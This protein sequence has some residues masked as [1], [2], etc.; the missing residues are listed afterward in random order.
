MK[1]L[2]ILTLALGLA[3][4]V[5]YTATAQDFGV[6]TGGEGAGISMDGG[7]KKAKKKKKSKKADKKADKKKATVSPVGKAVGKLKTFNG[8]PN[9]KAQVYI[10]LQSASWCGPCNQEMPEVAEAYKEMEKDG[11]AELILLGHDQTEDGAKKFLKQYKA[12]FPGILV[13]GKGVDKLPGFQMAQGI[14]HAIMVDGEGNVLA[15]GYPSSVLAQWKQA[16]ESLNPAEEEEPEE[17]SEL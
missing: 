5:S 14:P 13:G 17:D 6:S 3:V 1:T 9:K 16:V 2:R 7:E 11:R 15:S 4:S 8:K 10:Y 12:K